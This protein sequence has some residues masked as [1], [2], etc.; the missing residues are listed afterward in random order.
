FSLLDKHFK[1]VFL[2]TLGGPL[3]TILTGSIG[4]FLVLLNRKKYIKV[5]KITTFGWIAIFISLFWLR[6]VANLTTSVFRYISKGRI[7]ER[8]DEAK[9]ALYLDINIWTIQV[10]TGVIGLVVLF[11]VLKN[12][13]KQLLFTF[14]V[15]GCI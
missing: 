3:Q 14:I 15:S 6:Q 13:P 7:S 11:V 9:I 8:S 1:N 2:I 4:F 5:N 12:L 10:V